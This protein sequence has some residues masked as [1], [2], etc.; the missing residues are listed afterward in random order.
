M[1]A[2]SSSPHPSP[3]VSGNTW[4]PLQGLEGS[5]GVLLGSGRPAP[6]LDVETAFGQSLVYPGLLNTLQTLEISL[7]ASA[8]FYV[9]RRVCGHVKSTDLGA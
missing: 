9:G 3:A 8:E 1:G 4:A 2:D 7:K 6:A 5:T